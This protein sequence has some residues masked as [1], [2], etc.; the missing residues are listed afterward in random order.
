MGE[1]ASWSRFF[2]HFGTFEAP[3]KPASGSK[4]PT[5]D[6]NGGKNGDHEGVDSE[7]VDSEGTEK[8][9]AMLAVMDKKSDSKFGELAREMR[10]GL[11]AAEFTVNELKDKLETNIGKSASNA[12]KI[13]AM[14]ESSEGLKTRSTVHGLRL[15]D[16]EQ[17]VENFE[18]ERRRNV[19][20]I[21]GVLE[22]EDKHSPEVVD[23]LLADLK[24]GFDSMVCDRIYRRGKG[25]RETSDG[26]K[27][28]AAAGHNNK[29]RREG[30]V[31]RPIVVSFRSFESKLAVYKHLKN[32]QG[33][34]KWDKVYI[35]DDLTEC[36]R[37]QQ[38]DL[39]ALA[40]FAR[41]QGFNSSVRANALLLD[42]RKYQYKDLH[43]LPP[44]L[45]LEKAKTVECL[46]GD[47][48][49]FQ[50]VHS[51]LSNLYPC[52]VVYKGKTF[53][54][55]ESALQYTRA[56]FCKRFRE[57][58]AI[59]FE[60][61]AY[62]VKRLSSSLPHVQEWDNT[63]LDVLLEIL[64]IKFKTNKHCREVLLATGNRKLFEATGDRFWACGLPL[65]KIH[66]L[67]IPAPGR[68]C[69]GKT[70]EAVRDIIKKE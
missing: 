40:A 49:A 51:P 44:G 46:D 61:N 67:T 29:S 70:V 6:G 65:A 24:V 4:I 34:E 42:G 22:R 43:R 47:G 33:L 56:I 60:R 41:S 7:R 11:Q 31:I 48:V 27:P 16:L 26:D 32:L 3:V 38:R 39:R 9:L 2:S 69:T 45:S 66:E 19:I 13:S 18:R 62:E 54:S 36:Q 17:K 52:N 64:I 28:E 20:I 14:T 63:V 25:S 1:N 37:N 35:S 10:E 12:E 68:N 5:P 58:S 57:A 15:A 21:E 59:E 53:L 30:N 23:E 55:A 50:S 8:I